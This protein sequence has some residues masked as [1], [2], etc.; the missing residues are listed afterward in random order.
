MVDA[1]PGQAWS[2]EWTRNVDL[3]LSTLLEG[4]T[5][6]SGPR[7]GGLALIALG[8][9]ARRTLCPRSDIDLL[10]LHDG[11]NG[12]DLER[13]VQAICYPL[14]DAGLSV[15]HAVRTTKEAVRAA[16]DRVDT[17]TA[18][19]ERR[20]VAGSKGL[21]DDLSARVVRWLRRNAG[22][23]TKEIEAA[24]A[25]RHRRYGG[26]AGALEPELK[27]GIGGLR[28]LHSLRWAGAILLG[29]PGLDPLVGA[30]YLGAGDRADLAHAGQVLLRARCALHHVG[31][32]GVRNQL[33]LDLQDEVAEHLGMADGDDLLREVGLATRTISHLHARTWPV[34]REDAARGRRRKAAP[35]RVVGDG[36]ILVDGLL[37]VDGV[38][39]LGADPS[40]ALRSVAAAAKH[41]TVL[42]RR[43]AMRLRAEVTKL[44]SLPWDDR[45]RA[46]LIELLLVGPDGLP[47]M[48]DADYL[49]VLAALLPEWEKVR[50]RPQRNPLHTF[51]LDTHAMQA[52]AWLVQTIQGKFD[53]RHPGLFEELED[54][55]ALVLGMWLHDVGKAWPGNHSIGGETIAREWVQHMGFPD[56]TAD[57]VARLVR[58]HLLLPDT[59]TG[60]D[61]DDHDEVERVAVAVGDLET[62]N[63]L[64]LLSYGD[65]RATGKAAWSDWKDLLV[66]KLYRSVRAVLE[67]GVNALIR[68]PSHDLL[69]RAAAKDGVDEELVRATI[70]GLP[71][72]YLRVATAAQIAAH[73]RLLHR[74]EEGLVADVREGPTPSTQT[75]SLAGPD[76]HGLVA[77]ALGVLAARKVEVLEARVFTHTDGT[78]L[79]WFVVAAQKP[80][81]WERIVP[82]LV[83]AHEHDLDVGEEVDKRERSWDV[84]APVLAA[85]VPIRVSSQPSGSITRVDVRGPDSPGAM[86][87]LTRALSDLGVSLV[88]ARVATLGPEVRDAFFISGAV[89]PEDVIRAALEPAL[90]EDAVRSA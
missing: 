46:A 79:D 58:H 60:R 66:T 57:R 78:A 51:D 10:I 47:A 45:S 56:A 86:Y 59:A 64:Y 38:P 81:T 74:D 88:G 15:G 87:R 83:R 53:E 39:D 21:A 71:K 48:A 80:G 73:A 25:E 34:M 44:G 2:R 35:P 33:R 55:D 27:D 65:S 89:P 5:A 36:L 6:D 4:F 62:L 72:R 82:A 52:S 8:S 31:D 13:L 14:W 9:Y 19:T 90:T 37:E 28:D 41:R 67:G 24:D 22:R 17:A 70:S 23:L 61:I 12:R 3:A 30:R 43:T 29:E 16:G 42:G 1:A 84:K 26:S 49:G 20:L 54:P 68:S 11:W 18:M 69:A 7:S 40:L 85:P 75:L 77:D 32:K 63:G 50:G 76:R